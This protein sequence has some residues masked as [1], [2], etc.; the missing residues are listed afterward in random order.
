MKR[1][2]TIFCAVLLLASSCERYDDILDR[3]SK[4]E[5]RVDEIESQCRRLNSN[6]DAIQ[7]VL[8]A[9]Q[10]ND[11][12]TEVMKI[13]EDGEVVGYSITFAKAGTITI[14]HGEDGAQGKTPQIGVRNASDGIYYWTSNGD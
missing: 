9:V 8:S 1:L 10:Q 4:L 6:V 14:Y 7:T 5:Q 2:L 11:Y 3:L 13:M 12:V